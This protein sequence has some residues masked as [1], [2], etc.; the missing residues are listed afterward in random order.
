[1]DAMSLNPGPRTA[2]ALPLPAFRSLARPPY[3]LHRNDSRRWSPV[4]ERLVAPE[5]VPDLAGDLRPLRDPLALS[6]W[7]V[8]RSPRGPRRRSITSRRSARSSRGTASPAMARTRS[9]EPRG[10]GSTVGSSRR[11]AGGRD[12][13][14]RPGRPRRQRDGRPDPRGGRLAPDASQEVGGTPLRGGGR[15]DQALDRARGPYA[16]HWAFL[17]PA[18]RP[19]PAV[20]GEDRAGRGTGSTPG[21]STAWSGKGSRRRPRPTASRS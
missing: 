18:E 16:E 21:F 20:G 11:R 3:R 2:V 12:A 6:C 1:M 5:S 4:H 8:R 9:N 19:L 10:C 13:G 17:P 14:D 7:P 15:P